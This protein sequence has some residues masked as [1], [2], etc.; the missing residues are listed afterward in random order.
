METLVSGRHIIEY[1]DGE[2]E[3]IDLNEEAVLAQGDLVWAKMKGFPWWPAREWRHVGRLPEPLEGP[4]VTEVVEFLGEDHTAPRSA[5]EVVSFREN[6]D[7]HISGLI[8]PD[9]GRSKALKT[10]PA[11]VQE[12][13]EACEIPIFGHGDPRQATPMPAIHFQAKV[14]AV[15]EDA[16]VKA[17]RPTDEDIAAIE[18]ASGLGRKEV[19]R[20]FIQKR[21][22]QETH[23]KGK[24]KA[25]PGGAK[26]S[27]KRRRT[28]G[29]Q[30]VDCFRCTDD[31][32][33][34]TLVLCDRCNYAIHIGCLMPPL[35]VAP[36]P[37]LSPSARRP[38]SLTP[39]F[40]SCRHRRFLQGTGIARRA[41]TSVPTT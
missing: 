22:T 17:V 40:G 38:A 21:A 7:K 41:P 27:S 4:L 8:H 9:T 24:R 32:L 37:T 35:K 15:L 39:R 3:E 18:V 34:S 10:A 26:A 11:A 6:F 19:V 13:L 33:D 28:V 2:V 23:G 36:P 25:P 1:D 14:T 20:W 12:A 5:V 31:T 29:G 16:F 30:S